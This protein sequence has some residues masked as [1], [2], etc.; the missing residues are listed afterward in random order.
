MGCTRV[1]PNLTSPISGR[2]EACASPLGGA[3]TRI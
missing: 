1:A 2:E 3:L